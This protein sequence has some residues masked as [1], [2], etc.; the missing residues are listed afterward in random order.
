MSPSESEYR[1]LQQRLKAA[2]SEEDQAFEEWKSTRKR[3]ESARSNMRRLEE[4]LTMVAS[5]HMMAAGL[6]GKLQERV[7]F[8]APEEKADETAKE[9]Q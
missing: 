8:L 7:A 4:L 5:H 3:V 9:N 6:R 2:V 1:E